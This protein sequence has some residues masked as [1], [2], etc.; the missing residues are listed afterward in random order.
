MAGEEEALSDEAGLLERELL[1]S[2]ANW[3]RLARLAQ[4]VRNS[5]ETSSFAEKLEAGAAAA[6][7]AFASARG[8]RVR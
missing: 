8:R 4:L 7:S 5:F 6:L 2:P 1:A 3:R